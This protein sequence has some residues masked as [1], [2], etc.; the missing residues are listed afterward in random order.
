MTELAGMQQLYCQS[1]DV[2]EDPSEFDP[3]RQQ[4]V[5][6]ESNSCDAFHIGKQGYIQ[7]GVHCIFSSRR[8]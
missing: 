2:G 6:D 8:V 3:G 1:R 7:E 5:H 4:P